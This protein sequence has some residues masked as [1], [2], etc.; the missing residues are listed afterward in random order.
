M[1]NVFLM[2]RVVFLLASLLFAAI[3]V[4]FFVL[5][6]DMTFAHPASGRSGGVVVFFLGVV[7]LAPALIFLRA[8]SRAH[9]ARKQH[10]AAGT[11]AVRMSSRAW[12]AALGLGAWT[13]VN[14]TTVI[15]F[16]GVNTKFIVISAILFVIVTAIGVAM[17]V[18]E[19]NERDAA[20]TKT[21]P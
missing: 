6:I 4:G 16:P 15:A 3:A 13:A 5:G 21:K 10:K 14:V 18:D 9:Q 7:I 1:P 11:T 17:T 20:A 8:A 12:R 19:R 2:A